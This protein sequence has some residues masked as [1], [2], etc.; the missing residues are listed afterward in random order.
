MGIIM[1]TILVSVLAFAFL[2]FSFYGGAV[3]TAAAQAP[4]GYEAFYDEATRV[5]L[6]GRWVTADIAFHADMAAAHQGDL[7]IALVTDVTDFI[8][9]IERDLELWVLTNRERCGERW[10]AGDPL[11][12]FP[13][14]AIRFALELELEV[15][16]CGWNGKGEPGR[17]AREGG[18]VDVTLEPYVE[19]GKLQA[20][21]K[22][23]SIDEQTGLSQFLPLEFIVRRVLNGELTKLN[24][25]KKFYRAPQPLYDAGFLYHSIVAKKQPGD[26]IVITARYVGEGDADTLDQLADDIRTDGITQPRNKK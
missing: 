5:N 1:R 11:I 24:D 13:A 4:A 25:N 17:I 26:R 9:E 20:R 19:D 3:T 10:A 16:N 2:T 6:G 22:A 15:W 7:N 21:L 18:T 12:E 14:G 8:A 23:F